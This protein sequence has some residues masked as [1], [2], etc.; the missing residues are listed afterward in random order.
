MKL[1]KNFN[2]TPTAFESLMK[3]RKPELRREK[4]KPFMNFLDTKTFLRN[5]LFKTKQSGM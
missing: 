4:I 2:K 5:K 3:F 1:F